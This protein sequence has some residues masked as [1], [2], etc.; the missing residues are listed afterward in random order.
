[1]KRGN[2]RE[3]QWPCLDSSECSQQPSLFSSLSFCLSLSV[4]CFSHTQSRK[5]ERE[6]QNDGSAKRESGTGR[7]AR[8]T[9]RAWVDSGLDRFGGFFCNTRALTVRNSGSNAGTRGIVQTWS[10]L[11]LF[12][13]PYWRRLW[14]SLV[15]GGLSALLWSTELALTAPL[16]ITFGEHRTVSNYVRHE[17]TQSSEQ[18]TKL[19]EA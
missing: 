5:T 3:A 7:S 6:R 10:R 12:V 13:T 2:E 1:M 11:V 16:T 17:I 15:F 19:S 18:I 14:L 9:S 8:P 4:S